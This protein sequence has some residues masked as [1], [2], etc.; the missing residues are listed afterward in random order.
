MAN[1]ERSQPRRPTGSE[2]LHRRRV[3]ALAADQI[4]RV[5]RVAE[6]WRNG[7]AVATLAG[8]AIAAFTGPEIVG[9]ATDAQ[10]IQGGIALAL[11][12][13]LAVI[14]VGLSMRA[15]FG[16]P[17]VVDLSTPEALAEW[18]R[19]EVARSIRS[20]TASIWLTLLSVVAFGVAGAVL[21]FGFS[22]E[23]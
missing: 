10:R 21:V 20:L 14:A 4:T 5:R 9:E 18:E 17:T 16:W 23:L 22:V 19:V 8:G 13:V 7:A 2:I 12:L 3:N 1:P 11:A 6:Q 15:S